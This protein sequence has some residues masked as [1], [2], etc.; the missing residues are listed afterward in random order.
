MKWTVALQ[1]PQSC[2]SV[3][4]S[5][6]QF[7]CGKPSLSTWLAGL[8]YDNVIEHPVLLS[9]LETMLTRSTDPSASLS[10]LFPR[11]PYVLGVERCPDRDR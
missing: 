5:S 10:A 11:T 6:Q 7:A 4:L 2:N 9:C 3:S 8:N 1:A